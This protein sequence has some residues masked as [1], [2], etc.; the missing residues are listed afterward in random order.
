MYFFCARIVH[1]K[2]YNEKSGKDGAQVRGQK[3]KR[4]KKIR[5]KIVIQNYRENY[6]KLHRNSKIQTTEIIPNLT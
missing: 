3:M 1:H 2:P 5:R 6:I 4:K